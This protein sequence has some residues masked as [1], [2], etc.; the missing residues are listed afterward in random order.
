MSTWTS[1]TAFGVGTGLSALAAASCG[2]DFQ[3]CTASRTCKPSSGGAGASSG[4]GGRGGAASA[5]DH[6]MGGK[7]AAAQDGE[8]AE[9][10][11]ASGGTSPIPR[12]SGAACDAGAAGAGGDGSA[13]PTNCD[14]GDN[15]CDVNTDADEGEVV[16]MGDVD[17][18]VAHDD[19]S[20]DVIS[21]SIAGFGEKATANPNSLFAVAWTHSFE[22]C[23][24]W[25][26]DLIANDATLTRAG[27]T[28]CVSS[29]NTAIDVLAQPEVLTVVASDSLTPLTYY[30]VNSAKTVTGGPSASKV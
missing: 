1:R 13:L 20:Q 30:L 19:T 24:L 29:R 15:D 17:V 4:A 10:G 27:A 22:A 2:E 18:L 16:V 21:A 25:Q 6:A 3:D 11:T 23:K 14:G 8:G 5:G 26:T 28:E 7:A 9:S 12:D